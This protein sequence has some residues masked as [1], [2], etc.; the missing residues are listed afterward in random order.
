MTPPTT[1]VS[2]SGP[3]DMEEEE[4]EGE[5]R[6]ILSTVRSSIVTLTVLRPSLYISHT[7]L[8][9]LRTK[10]CSDGT[11]ELRSY[12]TPPTPQFYFMNI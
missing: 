6:R 10:N 11:T 7:A 8:S 2:V 12:G 5:V 1:L 4:E 3:E 9:L